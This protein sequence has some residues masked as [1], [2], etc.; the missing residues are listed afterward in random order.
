MSFLPT[1]KAQVSSCV[2][3]CIKADLLHRCDGKRPE[4]EN[5]SRRGETCSYDDNVRRRGP[6]K[7]TKEMRERAAR[8]A[9]AAGLVNDNSANT[10]GGLGDMDVGLAINASLAMETLGNEAGPSTLAEVDET[11]IRRGRKRKSEVPVDGD[12]RAKLEGEE[13]SESDVHALQELEHLDESAFGSI[14]PAL[15]HISESL[16]GAQ[17]VAYHV[18]HGHGPSGYIHDQGNGNGDGVDQEHD[19]LLA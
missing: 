17:S 11:G 10:S 18:D 7:R 15:Q 4:C 6:G 2:L 14:D 1:A 5:C 16:A 9:E 13:L 19:H 12:K 8:E 3:P